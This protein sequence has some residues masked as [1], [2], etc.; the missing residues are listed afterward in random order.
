MTD[1]FCPVPLP[2]QALGGAYEE[3]IFS[4]RL[5]NLHSCYCALQVL[6]ARC[7]NLTQISAHFSSF[8]LLV[9]LKV[10]GCDFVVGAAAVLLSRVS[11]QRH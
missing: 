1:G 6:V 5:D 11:V 9:S 10:S 3:F 7:L 8:V 2:P 4:P